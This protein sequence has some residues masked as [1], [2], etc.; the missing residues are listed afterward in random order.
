[1]ELPGL[2]N[3]ENILAAICAVK[4]IVSFPSV[5]KV[6]EEFGGVEHRLEL[7]RELDGVKYYNS[8]IDSSPSRT[9]AALGT[10]EKK[11]ILI[12]GGKDKGI[13]YDEIGKPIIDK[14]KTLILIG[15]TAEKIETAV[16][17]AQ[18]KEEIEIIHC[19]SYEE[20]VKVA[21]SLAK[22]GDCVLLSPAST[23]FDMFTNFE[24]RGNTFKR[25]VNDLN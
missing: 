5:R 3:C 18:D 23:S 19:T 10:F 21:R 12:A 17:N 15:K 16:K 20:V 22:K 14:V 7:I 25:L 2:H 1:M 11:I 4:G 8:S 13:P 24:E 6:A 9:I